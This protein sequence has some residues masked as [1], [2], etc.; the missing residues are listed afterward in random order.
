MSK[1]SD[2]STLRELMDIIKK[3]FSDYQPR[4][5]D[6][7]LEISG[8]EAS[9]V[10][11][12]LNLLNNDKMSKGVDYVTAGQ[13][14]NTTLGTR[15]TAEGNNATASGNYSHAEGN[16][17]TA[18]GNSSHAEGDGST[19]SGNYSHAEGQQTT[20]SNLNAHSEGWQTTASG[21]SSHAEGHSTVANAENGHAEGLGTTT[22][23]TNTNQHVQGKYNVGK[24]TTAF[25]IGNGSSNNARSN[26]FEVDWDGN[27]VAAGDI[28]DGDGNVLSAKADTTTVEAELAEKVDYADISSEKTVN[29]NPITLTDALPVP[30]KSLVANVEPIQDLHGY[31]H[32]WPGG[33]GKNKAYLQQGNYKFSDGTYNSSVTTYVCTQKIK[34]KP[35]T[36]YIVS[37]SFSNIG[38]YGFVL[39]DSNGDYLSYS[40]D[41]MS[42]STPSNAGYIAF[43]LGV[44]S[45]ST[46]T[47]TDV[48]DFQLEEGSQATAYE[49]Y[50]NECPILGWTESKVTDEGKNILDESTKVQNQYINDSGSVQSVDG[51]AYFSQ[52]IKVTD[53]A[54]YTISLDKTGSGSNVYYFRVHGYNANKEWVEMLYKSPTTITTVGKHTFTVNIP[55]GISYI[56]ISFGDDI[57][58]TMVEIGSSATAYVPYVTPNTAIIDLDG[59]RYGGYTTVDENGVTKFVGT[60][61]LKE[62]DGSEDESWYPNGSS[63]NFYMIGLSDALYASGVKTCFSNEFETLADTSQWA[64]ISAS[65]NKC[66]I[67]KDGSLIRLAISYKKAADVTEFKTFLSNSPLQV[68]YKL[69]TPIEVTLSNTNI[70]LLDGYNYMQCN[71]GDV[72]LTYR[73][74][75]SS[76]GYMQEEINN[77]E[78]EI[79]DRVIYKEFWFSDTGTTP[80]GGPIDCRTQ[81]GHNSSMY[82]GETTDIG[83][84]GY[85]CV[86]ANLKASWWGYPASSLIPLDLEPPTIV[87]RGWDT[88][89]F[90]FKRDD[91]AELHVGMICTYIKRDDE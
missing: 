71:S 16:T 51:S 61:S 65:D 3:N 78:E 47:P 48:T 1:I 64:T 43:N 62:Y 22:S 67:T 46:I 39:W 29:G 54:Q 82:Y 42:I 63:N 2:E 40:L 21:K 15:A 50:S 58:N 72:E 69:A 8:L 91:V 35:N 52:Y 12:A 44:P 10:E 17:A 79:K 90:Y 49:P 59:T 66:L 31:D 20:T 18:S 86:S 34:I 19:A 84:S 68:C 53:S 25:E 74:G 38:T 5:L 81:D 83:I 23:S 27:I 9:E 7:T 57:K 75:I 32:P 73:K 41:T 60:Y 11:D 4:E 56:R 26:A 28:T 55:N 33:G 89:R 87:L 77:L 13:K 6:S 30:V 70:P 37:T 14:A 45:G 80:S 76:M 85:R 88:A 36:N 24:S